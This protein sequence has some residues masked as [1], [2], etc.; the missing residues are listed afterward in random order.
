ME[1]KKQPLNK[2]AED[3]C[4]GKEKEFFIYEFDA[5]RNVCICTTEQLTFIACHYIKHYYQP[6]DIL[7]WL[8]D[9]AEQRQRHAE[10]E[11]EDPRLM[12]EKRQQQEEALLQR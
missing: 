9:M 4:F 6:R 8:Y 12:E 7:D 11:K 5:R 2:E 3:P 10:E 1:F